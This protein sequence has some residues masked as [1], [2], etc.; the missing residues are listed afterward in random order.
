MSCVA[1]IALALRLATDRGAE[2]GI[3]VETPC[4]FELS[5]ARRD[6]RLVAEAGVKLRHGQL[7][8]RAGIEARPSATIPQP[9]YFPAPHGHIGPEVYS[10]TPIDGGPP[11]VRWRARA[12]LSTG[13]DL[14]VTRTVAVVI[15]AEPTGGGHLL[16]S[17]R[18]AFR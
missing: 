8:L 2:P 10:R 4:G 16:F 18:K 12:R 15:E 9:V 5:A 7:W 11:A 13:Y 1:I 17:I 3:T 6:R 14:A